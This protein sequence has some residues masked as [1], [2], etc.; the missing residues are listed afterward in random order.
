MVTLVLPEQRRDVARLMSTAGIN[1]KTT[2]VRPGDSELS[3]LTGA[4]EPSG[5][6]VTIAAPAA[7]HPPRRPV[8]A[9]VRAAADRA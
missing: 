9:G 6:P 4:R 7:A 5:V 8:L 1:P 2:R 3:R